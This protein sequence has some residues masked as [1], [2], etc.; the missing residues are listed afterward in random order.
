MPPLCGFEVEALSFGLTPDGD[1][2]DADAAGGE[3]A[4]AAGVAAA[5]GDAGVVAGAAGAADAL[6]S[7]G[8]SFD[9]VR[10]FCVDFVGV[11]VIG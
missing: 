1:G 2:S 7:G 9:C 6:G 10:F 5:A 3:D 8:K 4:L 11:S